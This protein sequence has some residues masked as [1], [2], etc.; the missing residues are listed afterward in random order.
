MMKEQE[1]DEFI[2]T[3]P[4]YY[5]EHWYIYQWVENHNDCFWGSISSIQKS[6]YIFCYLDSDDSYWTIFELWFAFAVWVKTFVFHTNEVDKKEL[7][8]SFNWAK[9]VQEVKDHNEAR[10]LFSKTIFDD[11]K[12]MSYDK[13]LQTNYWKSLSKE[14][15]ERD[16]NKCKICNSTEK[17]EAHHRNY[18]NRW[19][20][21]NRHK[22][23]SD[24]ITLCNKCHWIYHN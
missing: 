4:K 17:L 7:R 1:F 9:V 2:Y 15:K 19:D 14:A 3:W 6:D 10:N 12:Y 20:K 5:K 24:L 18:E 13:Y 16:W 11:T 21:R 8:F 23:L 22:E